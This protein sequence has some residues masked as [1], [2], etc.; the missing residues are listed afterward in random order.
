MKL[1]LALFLIH[2]SLVL[3]KPIETP[4]ETEQKAIHKEEIIADAVKDEQD[5]AHHH[6]EPKHVESNSK[7][8]EP[9]NAKDVERKESDASIDEKLEKIEAERV[10]EKKK[11]VRVLLDINMIRS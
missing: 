11:E 5:S 7:S 2:L 9:S 8:I 6:F 3:S 10:K 1:Y 4:T